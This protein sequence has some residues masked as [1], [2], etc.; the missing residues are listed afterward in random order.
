MPDVI[1][2]D[3]APAPS[4]P[5]VVLTP[6]ES[7]VDM[8]AM[9]R[10]VLEMNRTMATALAE[11]RGEIT[12]LAARVIQAEDEARAAREAASAATSIAVDAAVTANEVAQDEDEDEDEDEG[13]D[14][15]AGD[16]DGDAPP[17]DV[18][19]IVEPAAPPV[20]TE[21]EPRTE[22]KRRFFI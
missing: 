1:V 10:E 2:T 19:E 22:G 3:E 4:D 21:P 7:P 5:V 15:D 13:E 17:A 8:A 20:E 6:A 14:E 12:T 16:G 18:I 9:L 11:T